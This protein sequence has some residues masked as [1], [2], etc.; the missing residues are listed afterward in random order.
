MTTITIREHV[1][2]P[3]GSNATLSFDGQGE[4]AL[5]I[6]DPFSEE[7]EQRLEW[8]FE[9]HLRFPFVK[10]VEAQAAAESVERYGEALFGQVFADRAAFADYKAAA[11]AGLNTLSFEIAGSPQF[12]RWHWEALKDPQLPRAF[13]L[14]APM[15]RKNLKPQVTRATPRASP[16]INL[17]IVIARPHGARDVGYRTISRP[18]VESLRQAGLRVQ[19][20]I[21]RPGTYPALVQHLESI[22]DRH[23]A[24]YYHAIHFD[25]HGALLS[26][27]DLEQGR[28]AAQ[29]TYQTRYGR[30]D[31][32]QYEGH[33]AF[34]FLEGER[35][36]QADPVEAGE[37]AE[38]LV[39]H[40][41]PIAILN[42]CQSGKQVGASETSLGSR[43][44]EA[45]LQMVLA[46]GYS[47]TVSAAELLMRHLYGQL[48]AGQE[49]TTAIRRARLELHNQKTRRAYS[50]QTIDLED[51]LLPVVY[52]NQAVRLT[53]REFTPDEGQA[54]YERQAAQ[55]AEPATAYGFVGRDLD[56]LQIERRILNA[57]ILSGARE[58]PRVVEG[59]QRNIL[60]VRGM[61]GAGKT[62]LL[63]Y[64]GH[65]WQTTHLVEQVFYFGYDDKAYTRQQIMAAM[66]EQL[67]G[68]ADYYRDFAPLSPEAQQ[69]KLAALLRAHRHL[70]ILDNLESITGA[71]LAIQNTL[72]PEEQDH[73][74]RFLAD[75]LNGKTLVL[76]GSRGGEDWLMGDV[77]AKHSRSAANASPLR[78][79]DVYDLP[80]LDPESASTL[81]DRILERHGATQYRRDPEFVQLINLL[82]GYPLALE[83][84]LSNLARQTPEEVLAALEAGDVSLDTGDAQKKTESILRCID[85]SFSNISPE[86]Q[87][88]L[89]CLAPFTSVIYI[90]ALEKYTEQLRAQPALAH[91]PF[92]RW[93][94]VLQEAAD[95]G[96]L[97]P[98]PQAPAFLQL[99]PIFPYFLRTRLSSPLTPT[100]SPPGRGSVS[101]PSPSGRGDGGE[102]EIRSSIQTAFRLHYDELGR[103]LAQL[104]ESKE[105][106]E[107]QLGQALVS[108]EYENLMTT[109]NLALG[110]QVSILNP[111]FALSNYLDTTHDEKRG[112]EL[113]QAVLARL[114]DYPA[115]KLAGQLGLEFAG[116]IDNIAKRQFSLKQY[117]AAEASYKKALE[118]VNQLENEELRGKGSASVYHQLG[119]V[120]QE[121]R[122]W[123]QA[124]QYYQRA[125]QI[126]IDFNDRSAQARTYHQLG[127]VA[128]AQR[129]WAQAEAYY[130]QALQIKIDFNDR[131]AQASTYHQLGMVA[132]EQR[133]WAQAEAYYQQTL[134]IYIDFNDRYAQAS[135]YHQ[136]GRVAQEQRQWAQAEQYYQQALQI[137]IDFKDRYS[138]ATTLHALGA[139]VQEQGQFVQAENYYQ[140]ALQIYIEFKDIFWQAGAYH[141]LGM[142][143]QEQRQWAQARE[144]YLKAL[145]TFVAY[146]DS[147]SADIAMSSLARLWRESNDATLPAAV[148]AVLGMG[149]EEVEEMFRK[150]T[151]DE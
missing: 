136:L 31:L 116:V 115:E 67:L 138:Q 107:K 53:V 101:P 117:P 13:A 51:W 135:T 94:T 46:M 111:V 26:F 110:A 96:L 120:A 83:V 105:A 36:G 88:L 148:A 150:A 100:L 91:L 130:Q 122:Q 126:Y 58:L 99:Q 85:Y 68:K 87:S 32:P 92:D 8:Y 129:Q 43:L 133:Q 86:A 40:Q 63:R 62:T 113:G 56:I 149:V 145:E 59:S 47:I 60:L 23:G 95:W 102:G 151:K 109:L 146:E 30:D 112:L 114:Q 55:F 3:D 24:G 131:Y 124:E 15:A 22:R 42:A 75:L 97:A 82:A 140:Q 98:H 33:K 125:L 77:G 147:Y 134:Q 76:L 90:G 64:L 142:V 78:G 12:H 19:I 16:T 103:A 132:Q 66:A 2:G 48:F 143:A 80:G 35:E 70:L 9:E 127:C 79:D 61:G 141:Q 10:Q 20:E 18:L 41:T 71:N 81:A 74:R 29:W 14:E 45:G 39:S 123:A 50:N 11:Q 139:V 44:M 84:V 4:Y 25:V 89:S 27:A 137:K 52:Q 28:E 118:L 121:Q 106:Q 37:L 7:E 128:Q 6:T 93:Q 65:W 49:V 21:L 5:T 69:Q 104:L 144:Y 38:L 73:L 72:P 54:Y 108:L 119:Y 17:L 34:L 57:S 1:G